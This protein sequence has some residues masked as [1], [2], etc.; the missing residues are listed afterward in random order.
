MVNLRD[1]TVGG[2][3]GIETLT[4]P[5]MLNNG[6][7]LTYGLG[8]GLGTYRGLKRWSHGGSIGGYRSHLAYFPDQDLGVIVMSNVSSANAGGKAYA[9]VDI[10]LDDQLE[11]RKPEEASSDE[12]PRTAIDLSPKGFQAYV[13]KY[14]VDGLPVALSQCGEQLCIYAEGELPEPVALTPSSPRTFFVPEGDLSLR[15][16]EPDEDNPRRILIERA[17]ERYRGFQLAGGDPDK[18]LLGVYYSPEL[19]TEYTILRDGGRYQVKHQRHNDFELYPLSE[20]ELR[21]TAY[22]FAEVKVQRSASGQVEGLRI[23]NGRV[24]NLWFK[25]M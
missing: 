20:N 14:L 7:T 4:T 3:A 23:S 25:K 17:G 21:G 9:L 11:P 10:L 15:I 8:I 6:D 13:G 5:G 12:I 16:Q 1:G 22:F 2:A 19:D 24:R 18:E